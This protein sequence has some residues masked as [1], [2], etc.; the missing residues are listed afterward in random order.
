[1]S[2]RRG[3]GCLEHA[4]GEVPDLATEDQMADGDDIAIIATN[5]FGALVNQV[6]FALPALGAAVGELVVGVLLIVG[7]GVAARG[8]WQ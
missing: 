4:I 3:Y 1:M 8:S 6:G 7:H 2:R 5:A